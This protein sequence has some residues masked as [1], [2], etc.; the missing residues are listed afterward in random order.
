[1]TSPSL[2]DARSLRDSGDLAGAEKL[3]R[4][5]AQS[6]PTTHD[7]S[8]QE[9]AIFE[10]GDL[11]KREKDIARLSAFIPEARD[12]IMVLAK[13]KAAKTIRNLIDLFD[14]IPDATDAQIAA[15]KD[16]IEWSVKEKR[17][18]LNQ[19]LRLRLA[20]VYFEKTRA[21]QKSLAIIND[22]LREFK[23]LDDKSSLVEVQ[24]LE[25][26]VYH[27][28]RNMAKARAALTSARTS[29]NS[30]YCP[31][32]TQAELDNMS[33]ILHAEDKDY[34]TAFSYFYEAFENYNTQSDEKNSIKVLK[35]MLLCKIMLNLIDEVKQILTSKYASK[36]NSKDIDAMKSISQAYA[37]RSL[38]EF[39]Q[40]LLVYGKELSSDPIIKSHFND[41]YD[42]LLEQNLV[43]V[44][45]PFSVVEIDHIAKII[46][47]DVKQVEG[48][49]SQMILD[50]VFY[51]VLDQGN[52]WL[53]IFN[54]PQRDA[55]YDSSLELVKH[56]STAVELLYEKAATLN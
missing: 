45:E 13:A 55:T 25:A 2:E 22:L 8:A 44:I 38:K 31:T 42:T 12:L 54:E 3:Y 40:A 18:F 32:G 51:G 14:G 47:L 7:F 16:S 35:Y 52:G 1:M 6:K 23:K 11:Y 19:S 9:T 21:F 41:L 26:K 30:I 49:L 29:A 15:L 36:Y 10:L 34:K 17:T 28:L 37:N 46:G 4:E 56:M 39:E 5:I 24:L 50:K 48:K 27:S 20:T 43:K 53:H 33:G